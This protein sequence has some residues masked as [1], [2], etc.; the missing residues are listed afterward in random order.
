MSLTSGQPRVR[1]AEHFN[2]G[3]IVG[4][5]FL[6][7]VITVE[8]TVTAAE[9]W[10]FWIAPAGVFIQQVFAY[11]VTPLTGGTPTAEIGLDGD[12]DAFIDTT[13]FDISTAGNFGTNIGS[14]AAAFPRGAFLNAGDTLRMTLTGTQLTAGKLRAVI[15]YFE[16]A[17]MFDRGVHISG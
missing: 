14:T 10:D 13:E 3:S 2:P 4:Q 11:V 5:S 8:K 9:N 16:C 6:P 12:P 7:K 1:Y 17:D 15:S